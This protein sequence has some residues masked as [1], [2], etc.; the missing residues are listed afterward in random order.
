MG[1]DGTISDTS[2]EALVSELGEARRAMRGD[3]LRGRARLA[4]ESQACPVRAVRVDFVEELGAT[5]PMQH[6]HCPRC[7]GPLECVQLDR[8]EE[9]KPGH[10]LLAHRQFW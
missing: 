6:C 7:G 2:H 1:S 9:G 3:I 8:G 4:C 10:G 5:R